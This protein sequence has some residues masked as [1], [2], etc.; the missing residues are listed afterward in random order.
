M[1][2]PREEVEKFI[3]EEAFQVPYDGSDNFY[4]ENKIKGIELGIKFA[5]EHF[6]KYISDLIV[7]NQGLKLYKDNEA[8][9][10][11]E[12]SIEFARFI[13]DNP[14][15]VEDWK[16]TI[17]GVEDT[18]DLPKYFDNFEI[19]FDKFIKDKNESNI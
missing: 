6:Y 11:K 17:L 7:E 4:N 2:I 3:E 10:F 8:E 16:V 5:E 18:E 1:I 19:L 14:K 12:I 15:L 9:R 13:K